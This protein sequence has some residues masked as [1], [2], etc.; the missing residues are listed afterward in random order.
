MCY[1]VYTLNMLCCTF[2]VP[3]C[4]FTMAIHLINL[5]V[6]LRIPFVLV[7]NLY[8]PVCTELQDLEQCCCLLIG[9]SRY[10]L[11]ASRYVQVGSFLLDFP[12]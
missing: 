10:A 8:T 1:D 9:A 6:P 2:D 5:S 12:H 7:C 4:T 3:V 11:K